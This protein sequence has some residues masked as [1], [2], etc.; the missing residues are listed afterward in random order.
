MRLALQKLD[1]DRVGGH[2]EGPLPFQGRRGGRW[3]RKFVREI[4]MG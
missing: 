1:I 2:T 4:G 3:R